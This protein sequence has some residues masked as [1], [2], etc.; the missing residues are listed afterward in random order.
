M[1]KLVRHI[2]I[3]CLIAIVAIVVFLSKKGTYYSLSD[4]VTSKNQVSS[5]I[6]KT[7]PWIG[8][9]SLS[10]RHQA[11]TQ[12]VNMIVSLEDSRFWTHPWIDI[13]ARGR[14]VR[15]F[16]LY[17]RLTGGSTIDQQLVKLIEQ[18]YTRT[19]QQKVHEI[20]S[21]ILLQQNGKDLILTSYLNLLPF[22]YGRQGIQEWC[23]LLFWV[24]CMWLTNYQRL[25]LIATY[26]TGGNP[27]TEKWFIT[28]KKRADFLCNLWKEKH[29]PHMICTWELLTPT[30]K[31]EL[32]VLSTRTP[33]DP[34]LVEVLSQETQ[35]WRATFNT[36]LTE[37][38]DRLLA[39]TASWRSAVQWNDCCVLIMDNNWQLLSQ[40]TCRSPDDEN[41]SHV[42]GCFQKRQVGS[43]MKPFIYLYALDRLGWTMQQS[44]VDEPVS[45]TL[46]HGGQYSPQNFDLRFHGEVS[47]AEA[48]GSSLNIPAVKLLHEAWLD[49][50][51]PFYNRL[52]LLAG[53]DSSRIAQDSQQ[54]NATQ[55]WLSVALGTYELSPYQSIRLWRLIYPD[56][57]PQTTS[58]SDIEWFSWLRSLRQEITNVLADGSFRIHGFVHPERFT[59]PGRAIK[60]GTSRHYVDGWMCWVKLSSMIY[61]SWTYAPGITMCVRMWN[62][63]WTPMKAAWADSAGII[64]WLVEELLDE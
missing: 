60:T 5:L 50:Y 14:V 34:V 9:K 32:A 62:Y 17:K 52:R 10:H 51:F 49:G 59:F 46:P 30:S 3:V 7:L 61:K 21:A 4:V 57:L 22:P 2:S 26:Q 31:N 63:E 27:F 44:I 11:D 24:P 64:W 45:F 48:L 12:L 39:S 18:A 55:L 35:N 58:S 28:V 20:A 29:A 43:L 38:V 47:L 16:I 13:F 36:L 37:E 54:F 40:N 42:N 15:D 1:K 25:F 33:Y 56:S 23:E 8:N 53:D 6:E 19:W 41:G